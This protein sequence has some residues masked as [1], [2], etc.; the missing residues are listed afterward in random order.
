MRLALIACLSLSLVSQTAKPTRPVHTFS[1]VARDPKTGDLGVAVQSHWF[2]VG[3]NVVW[4]EAGVGAVATQSFADPAY[5]KLGLELMR[6]GKSAP[7]TL[8]GLLAT[9]G[10]REVRQVGMVDAQGR[11]AT[12]TGNLCIDAAGHVQGEQFSAQANMMGQPSVWPAMAKA[13]RESQGDLADRLMAAL[14]AAQLE[15]GDFRGKQSAAIL[16]VKG[17]SSGQ[18]WAD[19]LFDLRV[20]D[21]PNP[22][23]E[24]ERL[25]QLQRAYNLMNAGDGFVTKNQWNE[26]KTAYEGAAKLAPHIVEMPFWHAVAL[27]N[28]GKLQESLPIFKSVFAR[29]PHWRGAIRRLAK[30]KQL[31]NDEAVLKQIEA[32]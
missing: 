7:E 1:I 2:A 9:D 14:K 22:L 15:G 10:E 25:I 12:H 28:G 23:V 8:K 4:A 5:G 19:K 6:A 31:P 13:F 29:E 17:R 20:E 27:V 18:P 26:A 24:L 16:I 11:V 32:Q 30:V 21:H 3:S